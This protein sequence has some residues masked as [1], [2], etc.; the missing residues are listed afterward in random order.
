MSEKYWYPS[1]RIIDLVAAPPGWRTV[2]RI[3]GVSRMEAQ[4]V[5]RLPLDHLFHVEPI[6]CFALVERWESLRY[7]GEIE[8]EPDP[9]F[10]RRIERQIEPVTREDA[11]Y[12]EPQDDTLALLAPGDDLAEWMREDRVDEIRRAA[13]RMKAAP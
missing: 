3:H 12:L 4:E 2:E 7:L 6:V 8:T 9:D 11:S 1:S 5:E 13:A 10:A